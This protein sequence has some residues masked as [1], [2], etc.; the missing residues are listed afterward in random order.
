MISPT[1][2]DFEL[3]LRALPGVMNVGFRYGEKGDVDAVSLVV[4]SDDAGPVRVVAKQIVSLYYPNATVS[5]EEMQPAPENARAGTVSDAGRVALVRA[6][7]NSHEGYCEVHL[8]INGR[9]GVGR[10]QNGPL[11]GGAEAT[12]DA[13]RQ[14]DFDIPFYLV[15]SVNVATVRGWP[16]IVTLRPR[17]NEADRHGVA[18][19][20]TELV[21]SAKATLNALNR[22]LSQLENFA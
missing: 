6:E 3:E 9:V 8:N 21:A 11:I 22:H 13:L 18:Q 10:S 12:L 4:H 16:V 17:A 7:F 14:L 1:E 15:G 2:E 5:V 19:A 20:E